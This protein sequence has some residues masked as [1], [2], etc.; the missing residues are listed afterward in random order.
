MNPAA[1]IQAVLDI[2]ESLEQSKVPMDLKIGDYMRHRRYIG[3]KDRAFIVELCYDLMRAFGR[4]SWW[5]N[6]QKIEDT[7]RNRVLCWLCLGDKNSPDFV[8]GLFN[9]SQY[10]PSVLTDEEKELVKTLCA[11][12]LEHDEMSD[13]TKIECPDEYAEEI[14]KYFGDK[15]EEE[16]RAFMHGASLD[17]RVHIGLSDREKIIESLEK[18]KVEVDKTPYSPWGLR[19]R[20][21]IFLSKTKAFRKGW[22]EIQDEGS[23]LIAHVCDVQPGTQVL[24]YCAGA[25]G[26]TLALAA[27]M[28]NKGRL[29]AMDLDAQRLQKSRKRFRRAHVHDIIE[30][31]PLSEEKNRKWLRRQKGTFD[32]VLVDVPCSGTGTWRRNPD[33]RWRTYGP[34]LDSL[35]TVQLEILERVAS[36]VKPGGALVYATCSI[37]PSENEEQIEKFLAAHPE[38][39]VRPVDEGLSRDGTGYMRLTPHKHSTDGFFAAVLERQ[40]G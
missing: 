39:K 14:Q 10:G 22:L 17:L 29:V 36:I 9:G 1:R 31:R 27:M 13:I 38:Y 19:A 6:H 20:K 37:L 35:R 40:E 3:S 16:M 26:K 12:E 8:D 23:Q 7:P 21:K 28:K 5:L 24:D 34:D 18:D 30:V 25:G 4:I 33:M 11:A 15:T 2:Y 32:T